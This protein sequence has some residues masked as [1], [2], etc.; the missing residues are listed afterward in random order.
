MSALAILQTLERGVNSPRSWSQA[1]L[2]IGALLAA[3]SFSEVGE[4]FDG[5][6]RLGLYAQDER[7]AAIRQVLLNLLSG[8]SQTF[9]RERASRAADAELLAHFASVGDRTRQVATWLRTH[10]VTRH[11]KLASALGIDKGQLTR[12]LDDMVAADLIETVDAEGGQKNARICRLRPRGQRLSEIRPWQPGEER[13]AAGDTSLEHFAPRAVL[14]PTAGGVLGGPLAE[15][16][17]PTAP[18]IEGAAAEKPQNLL[19]Y[20]QR[21]IL[22]LLQR[23]HSYEDIASSLNL[24]V[25]TVRSH[26]RI[27]YERLG[28]A[29]KV[30]AVM[31]GIELGQLERARS[32]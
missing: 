12:L 19:S 16:P 10:G 25:N 20:R 21:E 9:E 29:S 6:G 2:S 11:G 24:S 32:S 30:E 4:L 15:R 23:G 8:Y 3:G 26:L 5:L 27:I 28:A 1:A 7:V 14:I 17:L 31:I 13:L 22:S 18:A